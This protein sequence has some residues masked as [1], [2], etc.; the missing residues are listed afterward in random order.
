MLRGCIRQFGHV[1][2]CGGECLRQQGTVNN[3]GTLSAIGQM[4]NAVAVPL[5]IW[6]TGAIT[7]ALAVYLTIMAR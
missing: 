6:T 3:S 7:N 4:T 5:I 2:Q 1:N